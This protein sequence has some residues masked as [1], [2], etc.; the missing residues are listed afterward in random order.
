MSSRD[1]SV[2]IEVVQTRLGINVRN[3][4]ITTLNL[5]NRSKIITQLH[6]KKAIRVK[7]KT[8]LILEINKYTLVP[9]PNTYRLIEIAAQLISTD[10]KIKSIV[11]PGTGSGII[12]ISLAKLFPKHSIFASDVSR[13]TLQTAKRNATLNN[14]NSIKFYENR[15]GTDV[16]LKEFNHFPIDLIVA[17][18]PFIGIDEYT[19]PKFLKL[20]PEAVYEPLYAILAPDPEGI[21]PFV[22]IFESAFIHKTRYIVFECNSLNISKL[23][24]KFTPRS[25]YIKVYKD[26][27]EN[28]RF[29]QIKLKR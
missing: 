16:W 14:I 20:W 12:A 21:S 8:G 11:D 17:N 4:M 19:S 24:R 26:V 18:P 25:E 28:K 9:H 3:Y 15:L 2:K 6:K 5:K 13:A 10:M 29:M 23:K 7:T 27:E 22:K 1:L